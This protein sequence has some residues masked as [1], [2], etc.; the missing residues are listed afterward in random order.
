MTFRSA[1]RSD[2]RRL[3]GLVEGE[4]GRADP[5]MLP[6]GQHGFVDLLAV[7]ERAVAAV[8]VAD[9]PARHLSWTTN[10]WTREQSGSVSTMAHS[11]PRPM[12][13]SPRWS[14]RKFVPAA[15]D[16]HREIGIHGPANRSAKGRGP[17]KQ[18]NTPEGRYRPGNRCLSFS[19]AK[20]LSL[21]LSPLRFSAVNHPFACSTCGIRYP[22]FSFRLKR[23]FVRSDC[24]VWNSACVVWEK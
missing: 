1:D 2:R 22:M 10:A 12:R 9:V 11:V 6:F 16:G 19:N 5:H 24:R 18:Y 13:F 17:N 20:L 23:A 7:D 8:G 3:V 15:S 21:Y 4:L 14:S